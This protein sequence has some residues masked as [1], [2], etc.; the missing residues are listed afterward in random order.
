[1]PRQQKV[2]VGVIAGVHGVR[3][4]V[5]IRPFTAAPE[6]VAA[7]GAVTDADGRR[8]FA[9]ELLSLHK[10]QWLARVEGV[11]DR[12]AAEALRGTELYVPRDRLPAPEADEF[13]HADLIG[14]DAEDTDG[15]ALGSVRA[16]HDFGAGTILEIVGA[17]HPP[18]LVPFTRQAVPEV[19]LAAGRVVVDPPA[20]QA[21]DEADEDGE[22]SR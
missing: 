3:G 9:L 8:E 19:D 21:A 11:A 2:C 4:I 14:L 13:Y 18:L 20:E 15:M 22:G 12:T 10:G 16:V 17:G 6:G 1:M 5:K 7:Y